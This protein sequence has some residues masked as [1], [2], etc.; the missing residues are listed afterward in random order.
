MV[1]KKQNNIIDNVAT[2][3]GHKPTVHKINFTTL[4]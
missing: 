1:S 3:S 4:V 2:A